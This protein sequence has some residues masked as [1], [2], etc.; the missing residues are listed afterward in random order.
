MTRELLGTA[1][2]TLPLAD[3]F[4]VDGVSELVAE[5]RR[6]Y[7]F[8]TDAWALRLVRGYGTDGARILEGATDIEDL[9]RDFGATLTEAEVLWLMEHEFAQRAEDVVW[10]RSKLG[11]RLSKDE[12]AALDTWMATQREQMRQ[13]AE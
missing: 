2:C 5:L 10:R 1:G 8:L 13:A 9:G 6:N 12:I 3:A 4:P 7:P 11:L